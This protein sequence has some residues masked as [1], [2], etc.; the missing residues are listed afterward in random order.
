MTTAQLLDHLRYAV[1]AGD[2][3]AA[4]R[5]VEAIRPRCPE[6]AA[7]VLL[8]GKTPESGTAEKVPRGNQ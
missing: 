2:T 7:D 4:L 1:D 5:L 3:P 8:R 6:G